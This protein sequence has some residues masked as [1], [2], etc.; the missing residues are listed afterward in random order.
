[1]SKRKFEGEFQ[2]MGS[3]GDNKD[4]FIRNTQETDNYQSE[5]DPNDRISVELWNKFNEEDIKNMPMIDD[6][7]N[8]HTAAQW[9][10]WYVRIAQRYNQID[11]HLGWNFLTNINEENQEALI[12]QTLI[13]APFTKLSLTAA[14]KFNE[15]MK[16][17]QNEDLKRMF[18]RLALGTINNNEDDL[19]RTSQL[20]A[21]LE[22]IYATTKV[23]E[24]N[25]PE[26]CYTLSPYLERSMQIEKDYD[27]LI[28]AWKGWH[29]SCGNKVRP[30]YI[31]Y[32]N[33]LNKNT[34]ENGYKDLSEPWIAEYE[35]GDTEEF[36]EIIDQLLNDTIPLYE[37]LHAY[38]RGRLCSIYPNRFN[39]HGPIPAHILGNMWAQ[40][41]ND[42]F[43]DLIPYP[44][45]PLVNITGALIERGYTVH[46]MFTTAES[47]FTSI[48][49]YPMTPKFWIRS[50]FE[51]PT[52]RDVVCHASAHFMQYQDD[53]R[54][55][56]C[57]EVND[58]HFDTV[59]HELGH[60]EY[61][62]AYDRNQPYV[63][64]EGA[65]AGFHEAIGDTIG[66]FAISPTHLITLGFLDEN[67]VNSH[68]EINYLLRLALQKVAFLPFAYVMD[69][70]RF[71]LF[72]DE[73]DHEND[74]LN[75]IWWTL[76]IKHGGIM[77]PVPRNDKENFDAGAKYHIPSNVPYLRYFI[78]HILEFQLYRSMC[79]L[80]GVTERF[81]MCDIY[82]NKHVGEKL[83]DML[84]MGN[85][86]SWPEVLQ[87]LNGETKLDSGAILD[88]FQPL[89]EWLKKEN[90]AR[91]YPVGWD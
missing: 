31:P 60:I 27:R 28:W 54:V 32:I 39:C 29:D 45:A 65:N 40:Q 77:P 44:D 61:F 38:V 11:S 51:K 47:F 34:K 53:F 87:S 18:G 63:Y 57:T 91:G 84:D 4:S 56:M 74:E 72:R 36:E 21:E 20:Q 35:M 62:M 81:H 82:G 16:Y 83:K 89:Y 78:A 3:I 1:M 88:F 10:T 71:L 52:D 2:R 50:L 70:Y 67:V 64:Q 41:W 75:S 68:Y 90:D 9:L 69:K 17:S 49:L 26:K 19:K 15:Y 48:G 58:D 80:Q 7:S 79:Q 13:R 86:K 46:R 55:K 30:V 43:D 25:D 23:C 33:L 5:V 12:N 59:H 14:K 6:Y 8:E 85:S 24:S 73:I 42:R 22:D 37:Q 76:R 66:I